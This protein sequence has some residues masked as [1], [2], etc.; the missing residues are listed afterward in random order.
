[1]RRIVETDVYARR[2]SA[3]S[4]SRTSATVP[5]SRLQRIVISSS[6]TSVSL[7]RGPKAGSVLGV[8]TE[9]IITKTLVVVNQETAAGAFHAVTS[10]TLR[11]S[12]DDRLL[13]P[14]GGLH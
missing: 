8:F 11:S 7:R 5:P 1:M 13:A 2:R 10:P 3:G 14:P 12:G 4:F 9:E 6:S